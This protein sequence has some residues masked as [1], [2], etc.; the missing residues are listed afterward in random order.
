MGVPGLVPLLLTGAAATLLFSLSRTLANGGVAL[1]TWFLW[2]T[3]MSNLSFQ[4]SYLSET[5]TAALWLLGWW[6]LLHWKRQG[7]SWALLLVAACTGWIAITRPLSG[8][9]FGL[10]LVVVVVRTGLARRCVRQLV[11][12]S[13]LGLAILAVIPVWS[14]CTTGDW[15]KTPYMLH[16]QTYFPFVHL[17]FGEKPAVVARDLPRDMK[18]MELEVRRVQAVHQPDRLPSILRD[19]LTQIAGN[20][21]GSWRGSAWR[22]WRIPLSL[23]ALFGIALL[24]AEG[25]FAFGTAALLVAVYL[26]YAHPALMTIYYYEIQSVI[27]FATA[28]GVFWCA[29]FLMERRP[30]QRNHLS[31]LPRKTSLLLVLLLL[32]AILPARADIQ[33]VQE[34]VQRW[35]GYYRDLRQSFDSLPGS[36]IIVFIRYSPN[37]SP[38]IGLIR[39]KPDLDRARVW[40]VHDRGQENSRLLSV[41]PDRVAYLFDEASGRIVLLS[42][43]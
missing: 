39:N 35:S 36:K 4:A 9:A 30:P 7:Q 16:T 13:L 17:G 12:A 25:L 38:H 29:H 31:D 26:P 34:F 18:N 3:S 37:H 40:I 24:P 42:P 6:S 32:A 33:K 21:W 41:A 5:T 11:L 15:W 22:G 28:L 20:M 19:R 23:F 43:S 1:I 10:P 27:A 14:R 8:L 2:T